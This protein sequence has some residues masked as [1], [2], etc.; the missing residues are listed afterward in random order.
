[1]LVFV[2][3]A[4]CRKHGS[5]R[6]IGPPRRILRCTAKSEA[7]CHPIPK[8][9]TLG[10]HCKDLSTYYQ[11]RLSK[12]NSW[13]RHT[14]KWQKVLLKEKPNRHHLMTSAPLAALFL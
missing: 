12:R 8:W 2:S 7:A 9:P 14:R 1:M 3:R 13:A 5:S 11:K 6:I 4:S 10:Q